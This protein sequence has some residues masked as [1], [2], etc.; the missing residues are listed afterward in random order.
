MVW[1]VWRVVCGVWKEVCGVWRMVCVVCGVRCV[2]LM[3]CVIWLCGGCGK[4]IED[5][6]IKGM[7]GRWGA[8]LRAWA[9]CRVGGERRGQNGGEGVQI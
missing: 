2:V 6:F 5:Q 3:W 4:G 9:K 7:C 1:G 8:G